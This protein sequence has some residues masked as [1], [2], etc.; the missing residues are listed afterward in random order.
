MYYVL[1]IP[2]KISAKERVYFMI[3]KQLLY[4]F[5]KQLHLYKPVYQIN[6]ICVRKYF[7]KLKNIAPEA[8]AKSSIM[9]TFA[10]IIFYLQ[11]LHLLT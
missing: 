8:L 10:T 2:K 5:Y 7:F 9:L 1:L 6:N 11:F 4:C 3:T